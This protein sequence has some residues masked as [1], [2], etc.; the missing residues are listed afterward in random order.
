MPPSQC[1]L[2]VPRFYIIGSVGVMC[3]PQP[4]TR[5]WT[6]DWSH[7]VPEAGGG[8]YTAQ[9]RW[10]RGPW[11]CGFC[12]KENGS[13]D[14]RRNKRCWKAKATSSLPPHRL[15]RRRHPPCW[16]R[17]GEQGR[18][19]PSPQG[20]NI[21]ERRRGGGAQRFFSLQTAVDSAKATDNGLS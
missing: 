9:T 3:P 20:A 5:E 12:P 10:T 6:T 16:G 21:L 15:H 11:L 17:G 14:A 18:R 4:I 2:G 7:P 19:C 13:A 8:V 1:C